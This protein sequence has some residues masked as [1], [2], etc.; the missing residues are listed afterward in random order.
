M[1]IKDSLV[2]VRTHFASLLSSCLQQDYVESATQQICMEEHHPYDL[3]FETRCILSRE[4]T[5]QELELLRKDLAVFGLVGVS[6]SRGRGRPRSDGSK[7]RDTMNVTVRPPQER[8][9]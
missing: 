4:P 9:E 7:P 1:S 6:L 3:V 5:F 8:D 2:E